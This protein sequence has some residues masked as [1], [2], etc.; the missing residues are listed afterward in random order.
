MNSLRFWTLI[1]CLSFGIY[2]QV[3]LST[4]IE[5]N[6]DILHNMNTTT[7]KRMLMALLVVLFLALVI[8]GMYFYGAKEQKMSSMVN[9]EYGFEF[10]LPKAWEGYSILNSA[11]EGVASEPSGDVVIE[12]GPVIT[13]RHPQW[14]PEVPRQDIPIMIFTI[15]Q[16]NDLTQDKFHIGAT[17]INPSELGR[18][19][20]H[21]FA[22]PARYNYAFPV[23]YEE[24]EQVLK[25]GAFQAF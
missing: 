3:K 5:E 6:S 10:A 15:K 13:I 7:M 14:T 1:C 8:G 20:K 24:V 2:H 22:L 9:N 12:R 11:W 23:G 16:W 21:V 17:P 18:N 25:E 4:V 19:A